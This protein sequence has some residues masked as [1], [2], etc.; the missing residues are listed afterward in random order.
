MLARKFLL[1]FPALVL[2]YTFGDLLPASAQN[3]AICNPVGRIADGS[4]RNYRRG[5]VI[6]SGAEIQAPD[7]VQFLC[8]LNGAVVPLT[9]ESVIVTDATCSAENTAATALAV[10]T[11]DRTGF[12][13]ILCFIPKGPE[14]QFQVV[15][16]DTIS[17][18]P[19]PTISWERVA[20]AESYT[21]NVIG[22]NM[23][24]QADVGA[25]HT[26]LTYPEAQP[27]L[28][29]GNAY[30]VLVVANRSQDPIIASIV[31]NIRAEGSEVIRFSAVQLDMV[32]PCH[33]IYL[34]SDSCN[35]NL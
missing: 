18:N 19:R 25:E 8:F 9:G 6:C 5:Q 16:P 15:T 30:E 23:S 34:S 11:C 27:S 13:R 31:V 35:K 32:E 2:F 33:R 26:E 1:G 17:S 3:L 21:V 7:E 14:E 20:D 4:S 24:W 29:A 28:T 22:P 12:G 10:R